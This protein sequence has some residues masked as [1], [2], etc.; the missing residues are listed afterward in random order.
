VKFDDLIRETEFAEDVIHTPLKNYLHLSIG[1][2]G[3]FF[4]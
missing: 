1:G 2:V 3:K 4:P